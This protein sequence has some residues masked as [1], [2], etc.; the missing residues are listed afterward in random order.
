VSPHTATE[1]LESICGRGMVQII[2]EPVNS[3]FALDILKI[4]FSVHKFKPKIFPKFDFS[5]MWKKR[6]V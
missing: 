4:F 1:V 3:T 5:F 6:I 2:L